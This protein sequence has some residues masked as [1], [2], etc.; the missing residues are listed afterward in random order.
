MPSIRLNDGASR[1]RC[2]QQSLRR[3]VGHP[4]IGPLTVRGPPLDPSRTHG[5]HVMMTSFFQSPPDETE[6]Q[7]QENNTNNPLQ[8]LPSN[9][10]DGGEQHL[11]VI[12][13]APRR[14]QESV[15]SMNQL[16]GTKNLKKIINT[17]FIFLIVFTR[18]CCFIK[19]IWVD[20]YA[21]QSVIK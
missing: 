17:I 11:A 9:G 13:H 20:L 1:S 15:I 3:V 12:H 18:I 5:E 16:N 6:Q 21:P 14:D 2:H 4:L 19:M 10:S 8:Q 7:Q